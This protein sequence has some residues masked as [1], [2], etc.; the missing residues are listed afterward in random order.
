[1]NIFTVG[2]LMKDKIVLSDSSD[3]DN[4][5]EVMA[6]FNTM[7]LSG[8]D[9]PLSQLTAK[10]DSAEWFPLDAGTDVDKLR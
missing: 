4:A 2:R 9:V 8:D 3:S 1:M 6:F 10:P 7:A 5:A